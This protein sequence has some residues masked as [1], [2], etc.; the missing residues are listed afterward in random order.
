MKDYL[1]TI[2]RECLRWY[3]M[4]RHKA[5]FESITELQTTLDTF[6]DYY[7]WYRGHSAVEYQTPGSV[8]AGYQ[9]Q[10]Q[11]LGGLPDIDVLLPGLSGK[12][13]EPPPYVDQTFRKNHLALMVI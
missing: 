2:N 13:K 6:V 10:H 7:N 9:P 8:Y 5:Q 4:T 12:V 3:L 1:K 11:R